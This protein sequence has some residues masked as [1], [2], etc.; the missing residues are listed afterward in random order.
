VAR[1]VPEPVT[2]KVGEFP[3]GTIECGAPLL[4]VGVHSVE[5]HNASDPIFDEEDEI[6]CIIQAE[7]QS[8]AELRLTPL[9]EGLGDGDEK[10][11]SLESGVFWG[12]LEPTTPGGD[13]LVTYDCIE[14][15]DPTQYTNLLDAVSKGA[16]N[17]GQSGAPY[18]WVF[19]TVGAV[20]GVVSAALSTNGD[21]K[22]FNA[23]QYIPLD[24]QLALTCGA[25]WGV[26]RGESS[27]FGSWDW[28]LHVW[29]WGCAE[30]GKAEPGKCEEPPPTGGAGGAGGGGAGGAS[31]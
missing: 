21:D 24:L 15:D 4:R 28:E 18:G 14:S 31:G 11:M 10:V 26:R 13:I 25:S 5:V 3:G 29:A 2:A 30:Y 22:L 1:T 8:G 23:Q 17:I 20:A 9:V 16:T 19:S 12:Q 27:T 6:Y 7:A